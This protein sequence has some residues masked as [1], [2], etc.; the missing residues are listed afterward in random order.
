MNFDVLLFAQRMRR[1]CAGAAGVQM[2]PL[3][4][5][6]SQ[7]VHRWPSV[8]YSSVACLSDDL[9]CHSGVGDPL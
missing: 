9:I 5:G 4:D 6:T 7:G 3:Y 2:R 1:H 8:R